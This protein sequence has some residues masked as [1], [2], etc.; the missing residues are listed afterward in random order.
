VVGCPQDDP[1]RSTLPLQVSPSMFRKRVIA[2]PGYWGPENAI[3]TTKTGEGGTTLYKGGLGL[4]RKVS[5]GKTM[6]EKR[7][8]CCC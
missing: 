6:A 2:R 8:S 4:D 5:T 1:E 3:P 7:S